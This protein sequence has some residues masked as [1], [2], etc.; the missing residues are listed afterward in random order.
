METKYKVIYTGK[1]QSGFE[2]EDVL[3]NLIS[4]SKMDREKAGNFLSTGKPTLVKRDLD[5]EKADT[6]CS[7]LKKAGLQVQIIDSK[8]SLN[9]TKVTAPKPVIAKKQESKIADT[10]METTEPEPLKTAEQEATPDNPYA[11]P[12]ADLKVNKTA[13]EDW[14]E[15]PQKV[16]S[17]R[18]WH[19]I[20]EAA[21]MFLA[22]PWKW[23]GMALVAGTILSICNFIPFFINLIFSTSLI[24]TIGVSILNSFLYILFGGGLMMAAQS[25]ANGES[26]LFSYLFRGFS[27]NRNQ[28]IV[29]SLLYLAGFLIIIAAMAL[30]LGTGILTMFWAG[31][32][33]PELAA[34]SMMTNIPIFIV[35][36]LVGTALYMLLLTG[37]WF[38]IPLVAISDCKAWTAF[39]LSLKACLKN[40]LAFLVYGLVFFL[41]VVVV[42]GGMAAVGGFIA[43]F[44]S[45]KGSLILAFLPMLIIILLGFPLSVVGGLT[46]FTSFKDIF[47]KSA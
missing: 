41:L 5:R 35:A 10:G 7:L 36:M 27:H 31:S 45:N 18:G 14:L 3:S 39:K 47:Y 19:W 30:F 13:T 33:A 6:Y 24:V 44:L 32:N 22:H 26:R 1:L 28:L 8:N 11:S 2:Y 38:S 12:K 29:V 25:Q 46:V 23:M 34:T 42:F 37:I 17:S 40:W 9:E 21:T 16:P 43:F 15:E 4:I 20:K